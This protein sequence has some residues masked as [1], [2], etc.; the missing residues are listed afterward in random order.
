ME[1]ARC[2]RCG[3]ELYAHEG[4][5]CPACI[6]ELLAGSRPGMSREA[7]R[8]LFEIAALSVILTTLFWML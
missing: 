6:Q 8:A 5:R 3:M 2:A 1:K 4:W 7:L